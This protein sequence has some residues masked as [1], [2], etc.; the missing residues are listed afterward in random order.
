[1]NLIDH[2]LALF[3]QAAGFANQV[4]SLAVIGF[5]L[6]PQFMKEFFADHASLDSAELFKGC[7][8]D[9]GTPQDTTPLPQ[10]KAH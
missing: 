3:E 8:D 5:E 1:M 10:P 4:F 7:D 6:G 9:R 2:M